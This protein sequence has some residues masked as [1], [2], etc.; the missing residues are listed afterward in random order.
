MSM[1]I[2]RVPDS[3]EPLRQIATEVKYTFY[4]EILTFYH[5]GIQYQQSHQLLSATRQQRSL[6]RGEPWTDQGV[7]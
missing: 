6:L 5:P 2:A 7:Q 4:R 3:T 1:A